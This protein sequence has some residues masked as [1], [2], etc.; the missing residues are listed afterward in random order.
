M[1]HRWLKGWYIMY[2]EHSGLTCWMEHNK[3]RDVK[4]NLNSDI[5]HNAEKAECVLSYRVT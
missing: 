3:D 4:K 5:G 2:S 1:R